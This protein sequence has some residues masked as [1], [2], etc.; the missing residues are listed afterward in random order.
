M[1]ED[2][3]LTEMPPEGDDDVGPFFWSLYEAALAEQQRLKVRE[4]AIDN[5]ALYR[6]LRERQDKKAFTPIN[7]FFSNVERT[8]ANITAKNPSAEVVDLDGSRDEDEDLM[9]ARLKSWWKETR[10]R[11]KHKDSSRNME[12]YGYT[13]EKPYWDKANSRPDIAVMDLFAVVPAPGVWR[14]WSTDPP[15]ICLLHADYVSEIEA[16][17][18]VDGVASDETY[19]IL[20]EKRDEHSPKITSGTVK[21]SKNAYGNYADVMH[22]KIQETTKAKHFDKGLVIELWVRG[23]TGTVTE[24]I[25][26]IDD[27]GSMIIDLNTGETLMESVKTPKYRDGIRKITLCRAEHKSK[28]GNEGVLV[29]DD[30]PNPNINPHLETE[31][32]KTTYPW[33]RFP[34]YK[35]DS[36]RDTT[37][38]YGFSAAEQVGDLL[39]KIEEIFTRLY[40]Y[41]RQA[42]SPALIIEK[43]CG[44]TRQ[45]IES[46][47]HKPRL[48]LMPTKPG[49]DIRYLETPNLPATFFKVLELFMMMFDRIYQIQDAD[50]GDAP[51]GV[52]AASA[53]VA[54]Q[55]RNAVLMQ[56]KI[57]SSDS[58]CSERGMWAIGLWQNF[59]V[60]QEQVDVDAPKTME[61]M[62]EVTGEVVEVEAPQPMFRGVDYAGRKLSYAVEAGSTVPKTSLQIEEQVKW[63]ASLRLI[64]LRTIL[65]TLNFP[66]WKRIVERNGE[67]QLDMALNVLIQAGLGQEE[68][69][70]L[71]QWLMQ[72]QGGPGDTGGGGAAQPG[73]PR[74]QAPSHAP[75][76]IERRAA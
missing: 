70:Q 75:T 15:Y 48:V 63:L 72:P 18:G 22:P 26:V 32:A 50:R 39:F 68:A 74:E 55:E 30:R 40:A 2:W 8:V 44:I 4:T 49:A 21:G 66:N 35:A 25:P 62:D 69:I 67:S 12:I 37:T 6:G 71:K 11:W 13:P 56:S 38:S 23:A 54:L 60:R 33:G 42:L 47:Q 7:L 65:E 20:G 76:S 5:H 24:E 58:L 1:L 53:I 43:Y 45:M 17:Y 46:Q 57:D 59:G 3:T 52:I 31:L 14:D 28:D 16:F 9:T 10:Q 29:L 36:Y 34:C 51:S 61:V 41:A 19:D 27:T 73:T 64:D